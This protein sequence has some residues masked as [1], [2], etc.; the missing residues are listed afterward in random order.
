[1]KPSEIREKTNEELDRL[2]LE[3]RAEIFKLRRAA[4]TGQ[5]D[6]PSQIRM[7]RKDVA[8]IETERTA[9]AAKAAEAKEL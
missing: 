2:A 3:K 5:L 8:R 7:L 9:R 1:M 6:K 4:V